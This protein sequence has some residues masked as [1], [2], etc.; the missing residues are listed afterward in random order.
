MAGG[1]ATTPAAP[2]PPIWVHRVAPWQG[3]LVGL[4]V[5]VLPVGIL[6]WESMD[7]GVGQ[8]PA[9]THHIRV[10][11]AGVVCPGGSTL[12]VEVGTC[13][14]QAPVTGTP[15]Q[16]PAAETQPGA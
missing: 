2:P 1:S 6:V 4:V 3:V 15:C 13:H 5:V 10:A 9:H 12:P 14:G 16:H 11:T 8:P 7:G